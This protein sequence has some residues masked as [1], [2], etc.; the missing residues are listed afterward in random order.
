[1]D[2]GRLHSDREFKH[3]GEVDKFA[4]DQLGY[5]MSRLR[6]EG[7]MPVYDQIA[8]WVFLG[9]P[10]FDQVMRIWKESLFGNDV[11]GEDHLD[12]IDFDSARKALESDPR[13]GMAMAWHH[14]GVDEGGAV[15]GVQYTRSDCIRHRIHEEIQVT[16][17]AD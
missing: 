6:A 11:A 13:L 3:G 17:E 4:D 12:G 16:V 10:C 15:N 2:T 9:Q 8:P 1:M 7:L 5:V 14:L